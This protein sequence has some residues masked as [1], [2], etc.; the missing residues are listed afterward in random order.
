MAKVIFLKSYTVDY[1]YKELVE[2]FKL[3]S[4]NLVLS[5]EC[6]AESVENVHFSRVSWSWDEDEMIK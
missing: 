1:S 6:S 4:I 5:A 2:L 3:K